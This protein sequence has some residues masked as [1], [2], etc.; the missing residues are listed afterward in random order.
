MGATYY[1]ISAS[2]ADQYPWAADALRRQDKVPR[3]SHKPGRNPTPRELRGVLDELTDFTVDYF[4]SQDNWQADIRAN[5][6]VPLLRS[7]ALLNVIDFQGDETM[8][9]LICF[10]KGDMK[11]NILIVERLSR[12][13]GTLY[14]IPDTG[15]RPLPVT[16][17]IDP[18]EAAKLWKTK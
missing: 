8:P 6:G 1:V 5:A 13:C 18:T 16:P 10:E 12:I 14:V 17:G 7:T 2:F 15:A 11:L 3:F 9:H 4:V